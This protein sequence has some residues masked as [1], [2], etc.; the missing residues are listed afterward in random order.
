MISQKCNEYINT[1][2]DY[3]YLL[4]KIACRTAP[5]LL[6]MKPSSLISLTNNSRNV[7]HIWEKYK[8]KI[9][10]TLKLDYF[11]LKK[12]SERILILFYREQELLRYIEKEENKEFLKKMGYGDGINL[13]QKLYLLKK[14]FE[15]N[16]PHEI[17]IILGF[18]IND[19]MAFIEHKGAGCLLCGYWKVYHNPEQALRVFR[20]YDLARKIVFKS[21]TKLN[22]GLHAT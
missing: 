15:E 16:C 7:L 11:E 3:D 18:P 14:R 21:I 6:N 20:N 5:T 12:S 19:V 22:R 9:S 10:Y 4:A 8:C 17:G 2:N 1:L 13:K